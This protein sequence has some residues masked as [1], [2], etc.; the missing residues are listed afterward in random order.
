MNCN[1][2]HYAHEAKVQGG[3]YILKE[4]DGENT[5]PLKISPKRDYTILCSY[6][7]IDQGGGVEKQ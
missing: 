7:H 5:D 3:A 4:V 6:C 2:C 1:S